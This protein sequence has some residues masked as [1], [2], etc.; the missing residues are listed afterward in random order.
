V[1]IATKLYTWPLLIILPLLWREQRARRPRMA[2]VAIACAIAGVITMAD[3]AA[4]TRNPLGNFG[5]D[6]PRGTAAAKP[7]RGLE[8]VRITIA[9]AIWT[10][11]QHWD[12]LRPLGMAI[13]VLPILAVVMIARSRSRAPAALVALLGFACA[14]LVMAAAFIR[15][16]RAAGI[17]LPFGGKEGW[18]WY[19]LVPVVVPALLV[20][21]VSRVRAL[22]WWIV[23][24]DVMI[25]EGA[26]FHDYAGVTSPAHPT[27]LFRWGPFHVPF[28]ADLHGIGVGPFV[29]GLLLL[30]LIHLAAF[31]ALESLAHVDDRS[32]HLAPSN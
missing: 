7:I 12:A 1:A 22:A 20:P 24:W 17:A 14:Q 30:R 11:G 15:Q 5:F 18:Y 28:T 32:N 6:A 4:R 29:G 19:V 25:T 9:S 13:Y 8:M 27:A 16:A 26:L 21:A 2:A 23:A 10:S 3:L 31:F